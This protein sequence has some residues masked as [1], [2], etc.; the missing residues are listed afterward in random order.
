MEY[1]HFLDVY[2]EALYQTE[3]TEAE[4]ESKRKNYKVEHNVKPA[5][6]DIEL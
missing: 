1:R 6:T 3:R 2:S 5:F 4:G